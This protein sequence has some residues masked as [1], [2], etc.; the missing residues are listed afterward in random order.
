MEKICHITLSQPAFNTRILLKE[1]FTLKSTYSIVILAG[2]TENKTINGIEIIGFKWKNKPSLRMFW[3]LW[4]LAIKHKSALYHIHEAA[5]LPLAWLLKFSGKKII[6]DVN[7]IPTH[8][9]PSITQASPRH[10]KA[11]YLNHWA[12]KNTALL[13]SQRSYISLYQGVSK[14]MCVVENYADLELMSPYQVIDRSACNGMV[15]IGQVSSK[16]GVLVML[17][18]LNNLICRGHQISLA[19]IGEMVEPGLKQKIASLPF[20]GKIKKHL[21]FHN[22]LELTESY[23]IAKAGFVGLCLTDELIETQEI[24]PTNIFEYMSVGLPVVASNISIY[25][26]VIERRECGIVAPFSDIDAISDSIEKI[27][28]DKELQKLFSANG[29]KAVSLNYNWAHEKNILLDFYRN[30]LR[31]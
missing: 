4:R 7:E 31:S 25:R 28:Q 24:Y 1:C 26:A 21:Q 27:Y 8:L 18:V 19:V 6:Y 14:N 17:E 12:A 29:P 9:I 16:K 23:K 10:S 22:Q 3:T 11:N 2:N 30:N 13:L 5:L 20:Y 15:Y